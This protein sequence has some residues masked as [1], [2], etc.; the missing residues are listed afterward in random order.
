MSRRRPRFITSFRLQ[1]GRPSGVH[2]LRVHDLGRQ[3]EGRL[4]GVRCGLQERFGG[5]GPDRMRDTIRSPEDEETGPPCSGTLT[6]DD[7]MTAVR[8]E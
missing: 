8:R 4:P 1:P 2:P 5:C 6:S 7:L 3:Y